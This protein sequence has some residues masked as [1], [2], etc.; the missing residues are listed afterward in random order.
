MKIGVT[1]CHDSPLNHFMILKNSHLEK[2]KKPGSTPAHVAGALSHHTQIECDT[3]FTQCACDRMLK[4]KQ[5]LIPQNIFHSLCMVR[6]HR[7]FKRA[8]IIREVFHLLSYGLCGYGVWVLDAC[9][10]DLKR[11]YVIS[12]QEKKVS[13]CVLI[14]VAYC[15][16]Y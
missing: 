14:C 1:N 9:V 16:L 5:R 10:F 13:L 15:T 12:V 4:L 6:R 8:A 11:A 7:C 2:K 3:T